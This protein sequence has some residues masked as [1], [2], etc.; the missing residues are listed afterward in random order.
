MSKI[1]GDSLISLLLST[2]Y[3][4]LKSTPSYAILKPVV[5]TNVIAAAATTFFNLFSLTL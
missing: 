3:P 5:V 1:C 2:V 4:I